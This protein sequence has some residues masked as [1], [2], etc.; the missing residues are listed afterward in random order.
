MPER[1][2]ENHK[3]LN[4]D[5]RLP[6]PRFEPGPSTNG[7]ISVC[8]S[9]T[10]GVALYLHDERRSIIGNVLS[11]QDFKTFMNMQSIKPKI[12]AVTPVLFIVG[13]RS[14]LH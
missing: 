6:G 14:T 1:T 11:F 8:R 2:E 7:N 3:K 10:I 5:I 13:S 4:K 12:K 9:N